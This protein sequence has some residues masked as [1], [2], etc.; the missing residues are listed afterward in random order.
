MAVNNP[1][2]KPDLAPKWFWDFDY[3]KIDWQTSYKTI[4]ARILERGNEKEWKELIRF[5]GRERVMSVLKNEIVY[6]PDYAIE[7]VSRYFPIPKEEML[8]YTRRQ[9]RPEH[10]I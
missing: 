7:E 6:L 3:N 2:C 1:N 4:I 5:Y 10:W 8:C 9:L